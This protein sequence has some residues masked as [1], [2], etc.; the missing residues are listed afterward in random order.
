MMHQSR[1]SRMG[2]MRR[3]LT[4]EALEERTLLTGNVT[5]SLNAATG[6]LSITGD[7]GDNQ[8][9]IALSPTSGNIRIS[10]N[11]GTSTT[12]NGVASAD[13]AL[14]QVNAITMVLLNGNDNVTVSGF[15]IAG[16]LTITYGNAADV[17]AT[18]NFNASAINLVLNA[19]SGNNNGLMDGV[20]GGGLVNSGS[21]GTIPGGTTGA[22]FNNGLLVGSGGGA[23]N[24][25]ASG[26]SGA[27]FN[28]GLLFP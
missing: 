12:I 14:A 28:G 1:K 26:S 22:G 17:F 10:G 23:F 15:S 25:G 8:F 13:F 20:G 27:G 11:A 4:V 3:T 9:T 6:L 21:S 16:A 5:A 2:P 7:T 19:G 24:G 18:P